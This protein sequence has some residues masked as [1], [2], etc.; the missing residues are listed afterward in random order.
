MRVLGI[1]GSLDPDG[2]NA[3]LL[4]E[5]AM[6]A[7]DG[8]DE[9]VTSVTDLSGI[10]PF[11]TAVEHERPPGAT[12][13]DVEIRRA[14]VVVVSTPE[15]N[16][17]VPGHFKTAID[18][19]S[20]PLAG[21]AFEGR[22]VI[23]VGASTSMFGGVWAQADLARVLGTLHAHVVEPGEQLP[24]TGTSTST[25][26]LMDSGRRDTILDRL[27]MARDALDAP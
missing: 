3:R 14:D 7:L 8:G 22:P 26:P 27:A 12:G 9:W 10:P 16:G 15:F 19:L 20:R 11:S 21:N 6:I 17:G 25:E 1:S 18:W 24:L 5:I 4:D 2:L 23:I 13:L